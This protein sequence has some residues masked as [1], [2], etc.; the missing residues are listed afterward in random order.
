MKMGNVL[1]F[2]G[3][4]RDW[5]RSVV[6]K[7]ATLGKLT[8]GDALAETKGYFNVSSGDE[9]SSVVQSVTHKEEACSGFCHQVVSYNSQRRQDME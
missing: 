5:I 4:S 6:D 2:D 9:K 1:D 3:Y 7:P 8:L